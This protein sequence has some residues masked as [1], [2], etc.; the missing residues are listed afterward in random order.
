MN[1]KK[2]KREKKKNKKSSNL[3]ETRVNGQKLGFLY[4]PKRKRLELFVNDKSECQIKNYIPILDNSMKS[5][6]AGCITKV[7]NQ[8]KI[9]KKYF[10]I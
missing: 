3:I 7:V 1:L 6:I 9:D 4:K 8:T 5:P 2:S 10:F